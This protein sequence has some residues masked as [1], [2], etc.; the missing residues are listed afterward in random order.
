MPYTYLIETFIPKLRKGGV[1][2]EAIRM[3]TET[4][5][6]RAFGFNSNE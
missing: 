4:N 3:I 1:D 2:D 6:I 5:P